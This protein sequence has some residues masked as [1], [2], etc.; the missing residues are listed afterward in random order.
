MKTNIH[1]LAA[2]A[3]MVGMVSSCTLDAYD[4]VEKTIETFNMTYAEQSLTGVYQN[5]NKAIANPE[6]SF[7]FISVLAS[8]DNLG[9]GGGNDQHMQACDL[10][11]NTGTDMTRQFWIDRYEGI[12]RANNLIVSM[13]EKKDQLT[14][15]GSEDYN[16]ILGEALFLRAYYYYE[17]CSLYGN[18]PLQL[19]PKE[20]NLKQATAQKG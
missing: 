20:T 6:K 1:I 17:L 18:V 8:D 12:Q 15:D 13:R 9:G 2:T 19:N 14:A 4:H 10:L 11:R 5:L 7:F 16:R 3:L